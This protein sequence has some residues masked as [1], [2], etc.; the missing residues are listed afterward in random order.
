MVGLLVSVPLGVGV[1][2][3]VGVAVLNA[4]TGA[5]T[6]PFMV[7]FRLPSCMNSP[8]EVMVQSA[9]CWSA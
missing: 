8:V 1:I 7:L 3:K 9:S 4:E 2:V 6:R 5:K